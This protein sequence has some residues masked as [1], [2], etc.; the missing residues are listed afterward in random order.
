[1]HGEGAILLRSAA[2][3]QLD[4]NTGIT[5]GSDDSRE[6]GLHGAGAV[7]LRSKAA[8]QQGGSDGNTTLYA[9]MTGG[10]DVAERMVVVGSADADDGNVPLAAAAS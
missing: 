9:A 10:F 8:E 3:G 7:R 5:A 1:L 4:G 6:L 2:A